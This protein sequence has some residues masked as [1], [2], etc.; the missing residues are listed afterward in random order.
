MRNRYNDK[1]LADQLQ[2]DLAEGESWHIEFKEYDYRCL[3]E[4]IADSWKNDLSHELAAFASIGG[5]VYIGIS[6]DGIVKGISGSHQTWQEKLFER[7]LGRIKPKV[8]WKSYLFVD[9]A[10]GLSLIRLDVI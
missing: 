4:K 3:D 7:A 9:R 6:D 1:E 2:L 8:N 10:N 5:K